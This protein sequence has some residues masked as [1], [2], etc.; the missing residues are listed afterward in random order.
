MSQPVRVA[1]QG[2]S[3]ANHEIAAR[4]FFRGREVEIVPCMTFEE[5]FERVREEGDIFG[6]VAIEN[7]L[8]GSIQSNYTL[9]NNSG[10]EVI[11]EYKLRIKHNLMVLP[12]VK[13]D[14]ITEVHSHPMALAQCHA[15]F[16]RNMPG[17]RL[18]ESDD[19][20]HSAQLVAEQKLTNVAAIAPE[21]AAQIYGLDILKRSIE[22]N[23]KNFTRFLVVCERGLFAREQLLAENRLD[24][25]SIVFT[26]PA[27]GE[28]GCLAKVLTVLAFYGI[29]LTKI[30]SNPVVGHEW[31]YV[32]YCDLSFQN[33]TRY[34]QSLDAVRPLCAT[35]RIIGEYEHG[36]QSDE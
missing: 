14:D 15:F 8:V 2:V 17:V 21:I 5:L 24:R 19:T 13:M 26:L 29:N 35:L 30:Q 3:G 27:A 20:A 16:K 1:I 18:I 34:I 22:T 11:G 32:F 10:L 28:V 4:E 12:G 36:R 31:E 25:S 7:T 9:L 33:Y 23:K 6:I